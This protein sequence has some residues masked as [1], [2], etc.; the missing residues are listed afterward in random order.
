MNK[1]LFLDRD[2]VINEDHGYTHRIE[3]FVF[4]KGI[5]EL[6]KAAEDAGYLIIVITNQAGIGRGYYTEEDFHLL[7]K[8]MI[9]QF[10]EN[11]VIITGV[12]YCPYHPI[13]GIGKYKRESFRRKPQP[14]MILDACKKYDIQAQASIMIGDSPNDI[15]AAKR[16]GVNNCCLLLK[17]K[18]DCKDYPKGT[19]VFDYNKLFL[20]KD[21]L[22]K[23]FNSNKNI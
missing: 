22:A 3:D 1:A 13:H 11:G 10:Y 7:T 14:G 8:W 2:G 21:Y 23:L 18:L 9:K 17:D 6:C 5:I 16:A 12:E 15:I 19:N 4:R 20:V